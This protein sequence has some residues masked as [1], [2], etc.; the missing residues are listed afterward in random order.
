MIIVE[1]GADG[2]TARIQAR[3]NFS[4]GAGGLLTLLLAL[5][6]VTLGLAGVLA[7]Q[8]YWPI[9][10]I[11]AVQLA[12][13]IWALVHAWKRAWVVEEI[14]VGK[15]QIRIRRRRYRAR[16]EFRL[17]SAWAGV[18]LETPRYPGYAPRLWLSSRQGRLELGAYLTADEKKSLAKH[19]THALSD[20]TAW[21]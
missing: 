3:S 12:L 19:L 5:S 18:R 4:L 16:R 13:V 11:A 8:G 2:T 15:D 1:H 10:S 20:V 7:W 14:L 21:R 9:L 17:A 6:T